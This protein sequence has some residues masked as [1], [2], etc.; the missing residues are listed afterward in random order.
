MTPMCI[1]VDIFVLLHNIKHGTPNNCERRFTL[2]FDFT[3]VPNAEKNCDALLET[4]SPKLWKS[5]KDEIPHIF[6]VHSFWVFVCN[7]TTQSRSL[8]LVP[9][10]F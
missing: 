10:I 2:Y 3:F 6:S 8:V 7:C 4:L 9:V 5:K 1:S